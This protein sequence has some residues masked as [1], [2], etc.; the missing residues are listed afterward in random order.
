V[1]IAGRREEFEMPE[2]E[3]GKLFVS[4]DS[5]PHRCPI[6]YGKGKVPYEFYSMRG[7]EQWTT[8]AIPQ[9]CRSCNGTG[10]VFNK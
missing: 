5:T 9:K 6:C 3:K 2:N 8:D 10:I 7:Q 4:N 1:I